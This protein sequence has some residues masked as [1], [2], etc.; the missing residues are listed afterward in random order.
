MQHGYIP[1][2][3]KLFDMGDFAKKLPKNTD[4]CARM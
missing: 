4:F 3:Y 1:L 2:R